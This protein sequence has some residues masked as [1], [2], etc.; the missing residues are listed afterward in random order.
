MFWPFDDVLTFVWLWKVFD[1]ELMS[2]QVIF[3]RMGR[4]E[5]IEG[6]DYCFNSWNSSEK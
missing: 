3:D 2:C 5:K 6:D 1:W 4:Q